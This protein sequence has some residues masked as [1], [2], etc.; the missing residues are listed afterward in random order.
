MPVLCPLCP[1]QLLSSVQ[2]MA[3]LCRCVGCI[4]L[5]GQTPWGSNLEVQ[6]AADNLIWQELGDHSLLHSR[7]LRILSLKG[8]WMP[9]VLGPQEMAVLAME[10]IHHM[11]LSECWIFIFHTNTLS[12]MWYKDNFITHRW[13]CASAITIHTPDLH[14][15][16][17]K[18]WSKGQWK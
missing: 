16:L 13:S 14:L 2:G 8:W 18:V 5:W 9:K 17:A 4:R 3:M 12:C 15:L 11:P 6:R 10:N 7:K 1:R